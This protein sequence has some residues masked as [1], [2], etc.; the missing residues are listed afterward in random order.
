MIEEKNDLATAL[1]AGDLQQ[2]RQL[3]NEGANIHYSRDGGYDAL[4]DAM[5]G[6]NIARDGHLIALVKLLI[7]RGAALN[8]MSRYGETAIGVASRQGRFDV[9]RLLL[10]AG[11]DG[12][13]LS[14]TPIMYAIAFGS[15]DDVKRCL[16]DEV[17][18]QFWWDAA[19]RTPW[20]LSLQLGD[21]TKAEL[22]Y[23]NRKDADKSLF[24]SVINDKGRMLS[25]LISKGFDVNVADE[26]GHTPLMAACDNDAIE[27]VKALLAA[28]VDVNKTGEYGDC[29]I[30]H[31]NDR[32]ILCLLID[33]GANSAEMEQ[34][35][36]QLLLTGNVDDTLE[37]DN[38]C[39]ESGKHRR[40][41][42]KNPQ[43]MKFP[44]WDAM[45]YSGAYASTARQKFH[46]TNISE[47]EEVYTSGNLSR[48][49]NISG[50]EPV[51]SFRRF[52]QSLTHLPS[53][54]F[55]TM[56][57]EY[58]DWYDED[59]C[60]YNDVIVFDGN[61]SFTIYGYP[62]TIFSP[63]DFHSATLV[64]DYI[65]IIGN[66]GYPEVREFSETPVYRLHCESFK[67][68]KVKTKGEN[69]GWIF[70]HNAHLNGDVISIS[71]G[72]ILKNNQSKSRKNHHIF[73]LNLR[74]MRWERKVM[75]P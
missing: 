24:Q 73:L 46:D 70:K 38:I 7:E 48:Y 64:G 42:D 21:I 37:I 61:G 17:D 39:Y 12:D 26:Y 5:F 41:G 9:V 55:V 13:Y 45:I 56:G 29:A 27:C 30:K 18:A 47:K 50:E 22:L 25:W 34:E 57:G 58:E 10:D 32:R 15:V 51:W 40:F 3:L 20:L 35:M 60:I 11:A 62:P 68:E 72:E 1:E 8:G 71:A 33:A 2:V 4:I 69:P 44:F 66:L 43:S 36:R 23:E 67:I 6:R 19:S 54:G 49:R 63:T 14:W 74:T 65:Y 31:V 52:G 59:F 75:Q 53:G 16:H 28:G